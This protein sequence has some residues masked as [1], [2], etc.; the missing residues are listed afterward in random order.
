MSSN[1][2]EALSRLVAAL[3]HHLDLAQ[4]I[5]VVQPSLLEHAENLL[6]DAF[7]TYDDTLFTEFDVELPFEI[8]DDSDDEDEDE[9]DEDLGDDVLDLADSDD[10]SDDDFEEID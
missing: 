7:F 10:D 1:A 2:R 3:E 6:R 9:D 8:L 5:D 4:N